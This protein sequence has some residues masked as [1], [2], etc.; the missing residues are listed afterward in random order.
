VGQEGYLPPQLFP[1]LPSLRKPEYEAAIHEVRP[2]CPSFA[3]GL[4]GLELFCASHPATATI[5]AAGSAAAAVLYFVI[6]K[7]LG[8]V[9]CVD[10]Q[11]PAAA[12]RH[13]IG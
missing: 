10:V 7:R 5:K 2:R 11:R 6:M 1:D 12:C 3:E 13:T 4:N 9:S 8:S